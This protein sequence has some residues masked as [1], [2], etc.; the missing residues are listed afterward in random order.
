MEEFMVETYM[1]HGKKFE[2][3]LTFGNVFTIGC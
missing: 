1:I 3:K 2:W